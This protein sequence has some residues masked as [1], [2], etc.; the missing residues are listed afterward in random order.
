MNT[1]QN[2]FRKQAPLEVGIIEKY[3]SADR[4]T[5]ELISRH[6]LLKMAIG[7]QR[8]FTK[9]AVRNDMLDLLAERHT[10]QEKSTRAAAVIRYLYQE[11]HNKNLNRKVETTLETRELINQ[12]FQDPETDY[13]QLVIDKNAWLFLDPDSYLQVTNFTFQGKK[14]VDS[15]V[16]LAL[17][18][19]EIDISDRNI[20]KVKIDPESLKID[21]DKLKVRHEKVKSLAAD[22]KS[23]LKQLG[24]VEEQIKT[25]NQEST[26][27]VSGLKQEIDQQLQ[28]L[29]AKKK[30]RAI[31]LSSLA[32][33]LLIFAIWLAVKPKE[34]PQDLTETHLMPIVLSEAIP[35]LE[36]SEGSGLSLI[37]ESAMYSFGNFRQ[38]S[39][40][41]VNFSQ[42]TTYYLD[43]ILLTLTDLPANISALEASERIHYE[44]VHFMIGDQIMNHSLNFY[45]SSTMGSDL[46]PR[47]SKFMEVLVASEDHLR[48]LEFT[49]DISAVVHDQFANSDTISV[50]RPYTIIF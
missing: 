42:D 12:A 39:L 11:E 15:G 16:I 50:S 29:E 33:I 47:Q 4:V 20:E 41:L 44:K 10:N 19:Y 27:A 1:E 38:L 17:L 23:V 48:N 8:K 7:S 9:T 45:G 32:V 3:N 46:R 35:V 34:S 21:I 13:Q 43:A 26:N 22:P 18:L 36:N 24:Q 2:I 30:Q 28:V 5:I 40:K 25:L 14:L 49:F 31:I 6:Y 37:D